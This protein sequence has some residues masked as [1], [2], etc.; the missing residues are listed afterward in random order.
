MTLSGV[1][2]TNVFKKCTCFLSVFDSLIILRAAEKSN[3]WQNL[4]IHQCLYLLILALLL[5]DWFLSPA[6]FGL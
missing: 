6:D 5:R 2:T 1:F 3:L 4:S